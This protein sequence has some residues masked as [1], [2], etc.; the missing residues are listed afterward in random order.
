M[1]MLHNLVATYQRRANL[2]AAIRAASM[3]LSLPAEPSLK[4]ALH[5]ELRGLQARLN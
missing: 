3:R 2:T 5:A 4:T 1:R